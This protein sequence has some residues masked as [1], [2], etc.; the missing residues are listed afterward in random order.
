MK[1]SLADAFSIPKERIRVNPVFIGGDFGGKGGALDEPLCYLLSLRSRRPVKMV[2]DYQEE[3]TAGAP[4]HA[5]VFKMKTG[6]KRDGT[7]VAHRMDA[8][9]DSGAY[10]GTRP[11]A[12]FRG[13]CHAGGWYRIPNVR[14]SAKRVYTN[15]IPGG[16]M[17]APGEPQT[18]VV[19]S[20]LQKCCVPQV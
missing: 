8:L 10:G 9:F 1:Q 11:G 12:N 14:Q 20:W 6:V 5:V 16:Q 3:L 17:R 18:F 19:G 4:R 7:L 15:N 13:A 2:M